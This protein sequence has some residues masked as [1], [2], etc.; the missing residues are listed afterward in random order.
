MEKI[1]WF[2]FD[3]LI[4]GNAEDFKTGLSFSLPGGLQWHLFIE[5]MLY[6][7]VDNFNIMII[8]ILFNLLLAN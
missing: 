5:V 4:L 7:F 3:L 8:K 1:G 2:F 6:L